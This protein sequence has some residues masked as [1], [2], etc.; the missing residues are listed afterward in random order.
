MATVVAASLNIV[1][2]PVV[3]CVDFFKVRDD[4]VYNSETD[5]NR[6][7]PVQ[8]YYKDM[9]V[10]SPQAQ[11]HG[12]VRDKDM[13]SGDDEGILYI[14]FS[15]EQNLIRTDP[16]TIVQTT[17]INAGNVFHPD[18]H[19]E[20]FDP[21]QHTRVVCDDVTAQNVDGGTQRGGAFILNRKR[22]AVIV[23][24]NVPAG[25]CLEAHRGQV[26]SSII[27][28]GGAKQGVTNNIAGEIT[29]KLADSNTFLIIPDPNSRRVVAAIL[30]GGAVI[31]FAAHA[32]Y[33]SVEQLCG[34]ETGDELPNDLQYKD[35]AP[36]TADLKEA[37]GKQCAGATFIVADTK[38]KMVEVGAGQDDNESTEVER[39][40]D[41]D[42]PNKLYDTAEELRWHLIVEAQNTELVGYATALYDKMQRL[43][44]SAPKFK[45][46]RISMIT[47]AFRNSVERSLKLKH[48][49]KFKVLKNLKESYQAELKLLTA[50]NTAQDDGSFGSRG[51]GSYY[52]VVDHRLSPGGIIETE[53]SFEQ[54]M[55]ANTAMVKNL[56]NQMTTLEK[57]R[58]TLRK[59][60]SIAGP[61][62]CIR[63]VWTGQKLLSKSESM[64]MEQV[65][66]RQLPER[67]TM[68]KDSNHQLKDARVEFIALI[69]Q[70][71]KNEMLIHKKSF[72][73]LQKSLEP[74]IQ[75]DLDS[76]TALANGA[77]LDTQWNKMNEMSL[78]NTR[79][80]H[81]F[82]IVA[83]LGIAVGCI[84]VFT[85]VGWG[86]A[87]VYALLCIM[88]QLGYG[89]FKAWFKAKKDKIT[90]REAMGKQLDPD[91][92]GEG[93]PASL[94]TE[95][96]NAHAA[97][98]AN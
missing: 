26:V 34:D 24:P 71:L 98:V 46:A 78:E 60:M 37:D 86:L 83:I 44:D 96:Y 33:K 77:A 58:W 15:G 97:V 41:A 10:Y 48:R 95:G 18:H 54:R 2:L 9:P 53:H 63:R 67:Q 73:Q 56:K 27:P 7:G 11:V 17:F 4:Y 16:T 69:S 65:F 35:G 8:D 59:P 64:T 3:E 30:A 68:H 38:T 85:P 70:N 82:V 23:N 39:H 50:E 49:E 47:K 88:P 6:A 25:H 32:K 61:W 40:F 62:S 22:D 76:N 93:K 21:N 45:K 80:G 57:L 14:R 79:G 12:L 52:E 31:D 92:A 36:L 66:S 94:L 1:C 13:T 19:R 74:H 87:V 84:G 51:T 81:L 20:V 43:L 89:S 29:A 90:F 91:F 72:K 55:N 42:K 5:F 28:N 75:M